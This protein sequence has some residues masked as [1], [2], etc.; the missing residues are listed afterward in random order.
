MKI[1]LLDDESSLLLQLKQTCDECLNEMDITSSISCFL[2]AEEFLFKTNRNYPYDLIILDIQMKQLSGIELAR[3]IRETDKSV[4]IVF[5]TITP[6]FVFDGYEVDAYRYLL[7]PI[8]INELKKIIE[9]CERRKNRLDLIIKNDG[10]LIKIYQNDILYLEANSHYISIV[11][12]SNTITI[13]ETLSSIAKQCS[14]SFCSRH[15]SY[16]INID[17]IQ[18]ITRT[19]VILIN[20]ISIPLSRNKIKEIN[21]QFIRH[22]MR[23]QI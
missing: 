14:L 18:K 10:D 6:D 8:N 11:T 21:E 13:K 9:E 23:N 5:L 3:I 4:M 22:H 15:R 7:K 12:K 16:L 17:Y 20:N 1:A 19:N 2:S